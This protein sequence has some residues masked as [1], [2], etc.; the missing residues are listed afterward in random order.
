VDLRLDRTATRDSML[1]GMRALIAD[2]RAGDPAVVY[3]AGHGGLL[4]MEEPAP[5]R[6]GYLVPTDHDARGAFRGITELEWSALVAALTART[7][8]VAVIHDCCHA[9]RTV[10]GAPLPGARA[11]ALA[12]IRISRDELRTLAGRS[13]EAIVEPLGNPEAVRLAAASGHGPA[14]ERATPGGRVRGVFTAA[15]LAETEA[16]DRRTT[17]W[18]ELG[19]RVRD[20]VLR[21]T[22]RQRPEIEG[23]VSRR[24]FGLD[25]LDAAAGMPVRPQGRRFVLAAGYAHGVEP[26]DVFR[27]TCP[28]HQIAV[29]TRVGVLESEVRVERV[30]GAPPAFEAAVRSPFGATRAL[31]RITERFSAPGDLTMTVERA[32]AGGRE[33]ADDAE[34]G[35]DDRL[36]VHF[37]NHTRR[38]L[39][40]HTFAVGHRPAV[41]ALGPVSSGTQIEP[42]A[43]E[44]LG[45]VPGVGS[46]GFTLACSAAARLVELIAIA[47]TAPADLTS[48]AVPDHGDGDVVAAITSGTTTPVEPA[49]DVRAEPG[50]HRA[51][52]AR[53]RFRIAM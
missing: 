8:N 50:E 34:L 33:L 52:A 7:R 3:Y 47:T 49:R 28:T 43:T 18:A 31:Q 23:P 41:E 9:A 53:R 12:P 27:S 5:S 39:W 51:I 30:A 21:V 32:G 46:M 11:R 44:I 20:R 22:G 24:V 38:T 17:S 29:V 4:E 35:P 15:L 40:L 42:G 48:I 26:G 37:T 16:L 10:R 19:R 13:C 36:C 6:L 45:A 14:W 2:A 1:D 25:E